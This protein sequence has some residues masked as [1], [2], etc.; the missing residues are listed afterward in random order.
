MTLVFDDL[1]V[2]ANNC[3]LSR[4]NANI[5][6]ILLH[7]MVGTWQ[8]ANTRFN[9]ATAQVSAHW[10]VTYDGRLKRWVEEP[11]T[12]YHAGDWGVN[13]RSIGIEHEDMGNY[14]SPRPD[15]LYS[16]SGALVAQI[17]VQY[18]IPCNI[19]HV[20]PGICGHR[21][22]HAT[23]CP[24]S[25]DIDR[26]VRQ[27]Q[28]II[29]GGQPV[30]GFDPRAVPADLE[31]LKKTIRDV[32]LGEPQNTAYAMKHYLMNPVPLGLEEPQPQQT[33]K[34]EPAT[35]MRGTPPA[36]HPAASGAHVD[37]V[38]PEQVGKYKAGKE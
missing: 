1:A 27:A 30:A 7:T 38:K 19:N 2:A 16:M 28:N 13:L 15:L 23:A 34:R 3:Y 36:G 6:T 9:D 29:V 17:C 25:L 24:D 12:A 8:S 32:Q 22:V 20:V 26:I 18:K 31:F 4:D 33:S 11:F 5:D 35:K 37:M 10:G 21:D 14:N